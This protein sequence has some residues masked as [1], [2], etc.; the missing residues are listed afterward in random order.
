[1]DTQIRTYIIEHQR[2]VRATGE[3]AIGGPAF[4]AW[5]HVAKIDATHNLA[6]LQKILEADGDTMPPGR[7]RVY[8]ETSYG[9]V[10]VDYTV[11]RRSVFDIT[12]IERETDDA[13]VGLTEA[14]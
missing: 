6:A 7:Y 5:T 14:A 9:I 4:L 8:H 3:G 10:G 2:Y 13:V 11:D 12:H 1:M